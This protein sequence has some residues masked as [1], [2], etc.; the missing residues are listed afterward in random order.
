MLKDLFLN[1]VLSYKFYKLHSPKKSAILDEWISEGDVVIEDSL[2]TRQE[3]KYIDYM[4]NVQRYT[5]GPELRNKYAHGTF[6]L[7]K[8]MHEED[9][10]QLLKIMILII[11]KINEEFC[12]KETKQKA[13]VKK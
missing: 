3:Q 6:S 9:Y 1:E 5:N 2:F 7:D 4:L 10:I 12:L 13:I 8:N 11:I